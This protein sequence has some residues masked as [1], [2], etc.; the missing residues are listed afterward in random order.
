MLTIFLLLKLYLMLC[1]PT[2]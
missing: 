2:N 1:L